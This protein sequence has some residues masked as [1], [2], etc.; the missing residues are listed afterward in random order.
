MDERLAQAHRAWRRRTERL[1]GA[2]TPTPPRASLLAR[3]QNRLKESGG[4][5]G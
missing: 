5:T 1:M 4:N 3:I 2:V